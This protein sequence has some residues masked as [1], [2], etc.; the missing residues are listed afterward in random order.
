[1]DFRLTKDI[2]NWLEEQ[3]LMNDCD[4]ISV[5]GV[6]QD[7]VKNGQN[8]FVLNQI[9]L[10]VKLHQIKKVILLHHLDCGAYG[11]HAGFDNL[12][13]E[14]AKH[15]SEMQTAAAIIKEKFPELEVVLGIVSDSA[16][17]WEIKTI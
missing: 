12:E 4:M 2:H 6:A 1:M 13:Q 16:N 15:L 17:G 9:A 11:G 10:S 8:S 5:A 3:G 14:Q 7:I